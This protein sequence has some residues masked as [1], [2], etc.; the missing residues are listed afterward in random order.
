LTLVGEPSSELDFGIADLLVLLERNVT[1]H[2]VVEEDPETPNG[3]RNAVISAEA[4]PLGGS[5]NAST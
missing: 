2:H 1:A 4:N 5:V 3:G